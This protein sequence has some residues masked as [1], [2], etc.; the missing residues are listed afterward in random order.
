MQ[1]NA[2]VPTL[3]KTYLETVAPEL[4]KSLGYANV[5]QVPKL[6]KVVINS[7]LNASRDKNWVAEVQKEITSIAGQQAVVTKA[8]QS[9]SNFKLREGMN[10]GVA[11]TL[12]GTRMYDFLYRFINVALPNIRDFRGVS[13]KLDGHGNYSI[14]ISDST[15]FPEI[16]HDTSGRESIG[17]DITIVTS[18]QTDKEGRELLKQLGMPFRKPSSQAA[19][20]TA[21]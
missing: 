7:G 6:E 11:V 20:N 18:A 5:H 16:S 8:R 15:I 3:K 21:N 2:Y 4:R 9:V 17:M 10:N 12:R 1:S 14:G 19:A 13:Q